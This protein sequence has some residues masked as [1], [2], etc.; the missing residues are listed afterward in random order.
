M[1]PE[2]AE[3]QA[4][5]EAG[6]PADDS[7]GETAGE[8]VDASVSFRRLLALARPYLT[9]L[10]LATLLML[11]GSAVGLAVPMV[12]GE[13]VDTALER[14][15]SVRLRRVVASLIGL[16]AVLGVIGFVET[17]LLIAT[18]ARL[19][20]DLR[21]RLYRH[22][23][24]L[25][26]AFW[27][28]RRVGELIS[29]LGSDL[30]I[31]QGSLTDQI[32]QGLQATLRFVGTL[33]ILLVLQTRLTLVAL[34][35]VPPVVV[36]ARWFGARLEK[37]SRRARDA[38]A[39][40]SAWV[41]ESLSGVRTV[42]AAAI[43]GEVL[44]RYGEHLGDLLAVQLRN[45][46]VLAGFSGLMVF[47]GFSA[48]ALVLGYGGQLMIEGRLSAG[49]LTSFL[50][51]TFSIAVSVSQLGSLYA[52]YRE[53]RGA[54][55]RVFELLDEVSAVPDVAGDG[56]GPMRR[57]A[58]RLE[59]VRFRYPGSERLVLDDVS[60]HVAA[61]EV[62]ALVGPSG[63]GK[64]TVFSLLLRFYEASGGSIEIDGVAVGEYRLEDLRRGFGLVPQEIFLFSGTV[65][66]NLRI[67]R[68]E[69]DQ[70][71]LEAAA[72]AAGAHDFVVALEHGYE[73]RIGERGLRLSAG[74]RQRLAIAR[75]FLQDPEILL[76]DEATSSLDPE[77][78][79]R[80]QEG[81]ATLLSGR[82]TLVIAHRLATARRADRIYVLDQG[83][84]VASGAHEEL[85]ETSALY[86][87]YWRLQSLE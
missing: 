44:R 42:Q 72:R 12:A 25:A 17:Y 74:Q 80:V 6:V 9:P 52:G 2:Q 29:R 51:Y 21:E 86:R 60:L 81:V 16:F 54:S 68:S 14:A 31:V 56:V 28:R 49:E 15:S 10:L 40:A 45:A 63:A 32:P 78:E 76:L 24:H 79:A 67:V 65:A 23:V 36:L 4:E 41:E 8:P 7:G 66:E 82:T 46:R 3:E 59:G 83:R 27:D 19:L 35:V 58:L 55:A 61:G 64:S 33:V 84:V 71:E 43:E 22:L 70:S 11:V 77:S 48:F 47:S 20:R 87:R 5:G 69:A 26:P 85:F 50:L 39:E 75:A 1:R 34:I 62:V 13:V 18:G 57:G 30:V 37:L 38:S 73:T 53:L